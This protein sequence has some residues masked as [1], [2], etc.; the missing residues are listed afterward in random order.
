MARQ[1]QEHDSK[2]GMTKSA[3]GKGGSAARLAR[4]EAAASPALKL[5]PLRM[6]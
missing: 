3:S 6:E 1:G 2:A 5:L 4:T